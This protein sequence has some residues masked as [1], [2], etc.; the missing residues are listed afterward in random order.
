MLIIINIKTII[1]NT[2]IFYNSYRD[3]KEKQIIPKILVSM[4]LSEL[5]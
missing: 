1:K 2:K 3:N 5:F 4:D